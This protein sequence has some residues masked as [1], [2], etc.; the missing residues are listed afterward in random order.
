MR[1]QFA[2]DRQSLCAQLLGSMVTMLSI[3]LFIWLHNI[4]IHISTHTKK[5]QFITKPAKHTHTYFFQALDILC[6]K[7]EKK[8]G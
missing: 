4:H 2:D 6:T 5:H 1:W 3:F 8:T 7:V